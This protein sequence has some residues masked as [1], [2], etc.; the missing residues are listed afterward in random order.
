M[1]TLEKLLLLK[2]L[3]GYEEMVRLR[4]GA[5]PNFLNLKIIQQE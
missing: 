2:N 5:D 3:S 4:D 1:R